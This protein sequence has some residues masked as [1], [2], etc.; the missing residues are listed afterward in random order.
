MTRLLALLALLTAFAPAAHAL[1]SRPVVS[2][3][4]H[5]TLISDHAAIAPGQSFRLA[6]RQRLAPGWHTYWI[7]PGDAGQP[8]QVAL[9]LPAG[10]RAE[11]MRF[12]APERIPCGP[13]VNFGFKGEAVFTIPVTAPATLRPGESFTLTARA[14]WLICEAICIP[15]EGVFEL[16]IPVAA[17]PQ[18]AAATAAVF[19]AAEAAEPRA[20][21]FA[22]RI[23]FAGKAGALEVADPVIAPGSVREA[24]FFPVASGVIDNAAPQPLSL[25]AG[26]LTLGL[27]RGEAQ[28]LPDRIEGVLAITDRA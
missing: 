8:P 5:V 17:T 7:N 1:E 22:A 14:D 15:E 11:P 18:P 9:D 12:P 16:A 3:Q 10:A 2:P 4:A 6:L 27:A 24:F 21:P 26:S 19:A 20:A 23:G 28:S 13:L 25:R